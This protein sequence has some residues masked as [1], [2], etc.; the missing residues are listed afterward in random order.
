VA[1][2]LDVTDESPHLLVVMDEKCVF[3]TSHGNIREEILESHL[4]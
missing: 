1:D 4:N 3:H 2:S